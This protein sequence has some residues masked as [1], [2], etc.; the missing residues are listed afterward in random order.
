[1]DILHE[2]GVEFPCG[3]K[4]TCGKCKV[5]VLDGDI[6]ADSNQRKKLESLGFGPEW[7]LACLSTA[8]TDLVLEIGQYETIIQADE[9]E[10]DFEPGTG[11]GV[12]VD[13]G[14]TTLVAQLHD[15]R[16]GKILAV[17]SALN[18]QMKFG[19]DLIS[20]LETSIREGSDEM[21]RIIRT[22]IGEMIETMM[23][24]ADDSLGQV[25]VVGNTV[26]HHFFSGHDI[27]PLSFY[28]FESPHLEAARF[29]SRELNW[30]KDLCKDVK[31]LPSI[32]NFVGSD[33]LAG[34]LATGMHQSETYSVLIDLGTNGE[35][36]IGNRH[37]LL[38]ASTAAGPAFEGARISQGMQATT[39]AISSIELIG[40]SWKSKVIG[41]VE[42]VGICGS[43]LIDA[44]RV[45]MDTGHLGEFGE[46]LSGNPAVMLDNPVKITQ[47]D[48]QEFLLAKAAIA[49][50]MVILMRQLN[51]MPDE[52][53]SVYISGGFGSYINLD[54]VVRVG[55]LDFPVGKMRKMGNSALMGAKMFLFSDPHLP[56]TILDK[57]QH[58]NLEGEPDFQDLFIGNMALGRTD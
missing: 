46:I 15:M 37:K 51:V 4:G 20:R 52:V 57:A 41:N 8:E 12:A 29:T 47:K 48:I 6:K 5:K 45:L 42:P 17:E 24:G 58:I 28:P 32:G 44:V 54:N 30:S 50:G 39:G 35:I 9:S 23:I 43:G 11:L 14:T 7:R 31:F 56:D 55:M 13:L 25:V 22:K 18:P 10:F 16:S 34:I 2:F 3:G 26:M 49:A 33:I 27:T 19:N 40:K 53:E 36:V 21:I 38:C 1:M